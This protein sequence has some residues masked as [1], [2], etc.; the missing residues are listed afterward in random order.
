MAIQPAG[1]VHFKI[2]M[3][4]K[5]NMRRRLSGHPLAH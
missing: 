4:E 1:L 5:Y 3:V 2:V